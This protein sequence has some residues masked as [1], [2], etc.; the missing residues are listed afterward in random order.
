[1]AVSS[2]LQGKPQRGGALTT[3]AGR[4]LS[5]LAVLRALTWQ[6]GRRTWASCAGRQWAGV[7]S[8]VGWAA[9]HK[10]A[11]LCPSQVGLPEDRQANRSTRRSAGPLA[12]YKGEPSG[13]EVLQQSPATQALISHMTC[14]TAQTRENPGREV[15]PSVKH[16]ARLRRPGSCAGVIPAAH[17]IPA[18][19]GAPPGGA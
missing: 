17:I 9:V 10:A 15:T 16:Q 14:P 3:G 1:M 4:R 5:A 7:P 6:R 19:W 11:P 2:G 18:A 13:V 12:P 8:Q